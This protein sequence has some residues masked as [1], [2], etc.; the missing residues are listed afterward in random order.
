MN[1]KILL[2]AATIALMLLAVAVTS[3]TALKNH[4]VIQMNTLPGTDAT[5]SAHMKST[6]DCST[7]EP[8]VIKESNIPKGQATIRADAG[9][10]GRIVRTVALGDT[11]RVIG[12][13][14]LNILKAASTIQVTVK[15]DGQSD[16][17]TYP[18][19]TLELVAPNIWQ[20]YF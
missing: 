14:M 1:K 18:C 16:S 4:G 15:L 13:N 3:R 7:P 11:T 2:F 19:D 8:C 10:D 9:S 17:V 12:P 20:C 6:E 5:I